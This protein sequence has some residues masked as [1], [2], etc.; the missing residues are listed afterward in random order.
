MKK[1]L[2]RFVLLSIAVIFALTAGLPN[3]MADNYRYQGNVEFYFSNDGGA[4]YGREGRI[5][6]SDETILMQVRFSVAIVNRKLFTSRTSQV[7]AVL[8]IP[9]TDAVDV[10]YMEGQI[11][12]PTIDYA[13]SVIRYEYTVTAESEP[14]EQRIIFQLKPN[15]AVSM[16]MTF[17]FDENADI[18]PVSNSQHT[19]EFIERE[20]IIEEPEEVDEVIDGESNDGNR[21][22]AEEERKSNASYG[23]Q[24]SS[25]NLLYIVFIGV[26]V[27]VIMSITTLIVV[28]IKLPQRKQ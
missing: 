7:S 10:V 20:I 15:A 26:G 11:I 17:E 2:S 27:A 5:F 21:G 25:D 8:T 13:N 6:Y 14:V 24:A 9:N 22:N 12:E 3:A 18:D 23:S 28:L 19:V 4:R 1:R 16:R